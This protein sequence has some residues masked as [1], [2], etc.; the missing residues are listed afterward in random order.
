MKEDGTTRNQGNNSPIVP[1]SLAD[2]TVLDQVLES[3]LVYLRGATLLARKHAAQIQVVEGLRRRLA[4]IP[5]DTQG[6]PVLLTFNEVEAL[7]RAVEKY[8]SIY[9]QCVPRS[10]ERDAVLER[11]EAFRQ[12]LSRMLCPL[13]D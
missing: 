5:P 13:V 4:M 9:R 8:M 6:T 11:F 3:Y 7:D 10:I 1:L 12:E 2:V